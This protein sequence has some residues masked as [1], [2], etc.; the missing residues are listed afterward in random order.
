MLVALAIKPVSIAN[1]VVL[2]LL[3]NLECSFGF[4]ESPFALASCFHALISLANYLIPFFFFFFP[5]VFQC[6]IVYQ[7]DLI[8]SKQA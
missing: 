8:K 4:V 6:V 2:V 5:Y 1:I 3:V 7:Y